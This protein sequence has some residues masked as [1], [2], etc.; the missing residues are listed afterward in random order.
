MIREILQIL[1]NFIKSR[2]FIAFLVMTLLSSLLLYRVFELQIVNADKYVAKYTQKTEK[3]R[4][5]NATRGNIYD[6]DGNLLAYNVSVYSVVME[7]IL[8]SGAMKSE[9]MN[10][11]ISTTIDIINRHGDSI[12]RDFPL[13]YSDGHIIWQ[14]SLSQ[15]SKERFLKDI[16]GVKTL[17]TEEEKLSETTAEGAYNYLI[18]EKK[19]NI[20]TELYTKDRTLDIAMIRYNLSL[21][22]YQKYISTTIAT[23][24]SEETMA[25][26]Y[27]SADIIPGVTISQ[28]TKRIY[29]DSIYF[30][31]IIGYTGKISDEQRGELNSQIS[32]GT[33]EY[34]L[35]DIVGKTGVE[36]SMELELAGN[37]GYERVI[38]DNT[39]KVL[40]TVEKKD[41]ESGKDVYLT[42]RSDLQK[43]IYH[44]IEQNLA[45]ILLDKIVNRSLTEKD[46]EKWLIPIKKVYFQIINNNI[47]DIDEFDRENASENEKA[48]YQK[49]VNKK[50]TVLANISS[51]LYNNEA[52]GLKSLSTEFNDYYTFIFNS[53]ADSSYGLEILSRDRIDTEDEIYKKW[54]RD[55]IS[56]REILLHAID[57]NWIDTS[58]LDVETSYIDRETIF[59]S[60]IDYINEYLKDSSD[61][62]K[63]LYEYL[64]EYGQVTGSQVCKL[65]Y[66]QGVLE[67]DATVYSQLT[68]GT[69]SPYQFMLNKIK[70]LEITPAMLAIEPCSA[71]VTVVE[72]GTSNVL[73]MVSYPSYDNNA[74]SGRID[75]DTWNTLSSDLSSPLFDRATKMRTAPGSTFKPLSGIA[76]LETGVISPNSV[77]VCNG[78]YDT[79]EPPP[80]CWIYPG[81]HGGLSVVTGIE[82]SCN[83]FF[84][85]VAYRLSTLNGNYDESAGLAILKKYGSMVGLDEKSGVEVEEYPPSFS[86]TNPIASAIG[87]GSH[88]FTGVQLARYVNTIASNGQNYEL[89]LIKDIVDSDGT[90]NELPEKKVTT[91]DINLDNLSYIKTGM[92]KAA[93]SYAALKN[94]DITVAAK[95]GTAQENANLPDHALMIAFA[96]YEDPEISLNVTIQNGYT[97]SYASNV[98]ADVIQFY[99]G[100]LTLEQILNGDA[101]GPKQLEETEADEEQN[102]IEN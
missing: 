52:V 38:V 78:I 74:F 102:L 47:V 43:G 11:L 66:D 7:D 40:S 20:D 59:S 65:L 34:E 35:N 97:S 80:K 46:K 28:T 58:K 57:M 12:D 5:S 2:V 75:S 15:T 32:D 6:A 72:S 23:D 91:M 90:K 92:R 60:L 77:I 29:N 25:A 41:G 45:S 36:A 64:I 85:E 82:D 8:D 62:D 94:L 49:L 99:F 54:M 26:I 95:T 70:A 21:N 4:Y 13:E 10:T 31:H 27:E 9:Q 84:Y 50:E 16:F 100:E 14:R 88:S 39:G 3:T 69:L 48:V 101:N 24:V 76:G 63:I 33:K 51:E 93:L 83:C 71:T 55:E 44:L 87:Q 1:Y 37:K 81:R 56:L 68:N 61:F 22:A 17:D 53:L 96:P 89:T 19:Y 73:A 67:Y 98:A 86:T 42:I 30:A 18:S 79:I